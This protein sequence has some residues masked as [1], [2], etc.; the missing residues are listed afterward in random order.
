MACHFERVAEIEGNFCSTFCVQL[1]WVK[2]LGKDPP[3]VL[4]TVS[5]K[6]HLSNFFRR[7]VLVSWLYEQT[8]F[9]S[10]LKKPISPDA[11]WGNPF[12]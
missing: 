1:F 11:I 2:S 8:F 3:K 5:K 12:G 9:I 6:R 10:D 4:E 7:Q